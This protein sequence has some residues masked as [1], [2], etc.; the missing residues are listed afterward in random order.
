MATNYQPPL[1]L[2]CTRASLVQAAAQVPFVPYPRLRTFQQLLM[3]PS[4][5]P[6]RE[7]VGV[8]HTYACTMPTCSPLT[9]QD[10]P[11]SGHSVTV[12]RS[13]PVKPRGLGGRAAT[14]AGHRTLLPTSTEMKSSVLLTQG[15]WFQQTGWCNVNTRAGP[16][17]AGLVK[18]ELCRLPRRRDRAPGRA[19][20]RSGL[21]PGALGMVV[22]AGTTLCSAGN[23][24]VVPPSQGH[25]CLHCQAA[26]HTQPTPP[27]A[28]H[29][30]THVPHL[31]ICGIALHGGLQR[32]APRRGLTSAHASPEASALPAVRHLR[33]SEPP[34]SAEP[35]IG[36][37]DGTW[38][39]GAAGSPISQQ[40]I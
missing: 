33:P 25:L 13:W 4:R 1:A 29:G 17:A 23:L 21:V 34:A 16:A 7:A 40:R 11:Q 10:A 24:L 32:P 2:V 20:D 3:H 19:P 38:A 8:Q 37:E 39:A 35:F 12:S 28:N 14:L 9:F 18:F 15:L 6:N 5:V 22:G 27:T 26:P 30:Y 31:Q 36:R